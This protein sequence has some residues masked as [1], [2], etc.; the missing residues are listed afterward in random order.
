MNETTFVVT[1]LIA[2]PMEERENPCFCFDS[3]QDVCNFM[4][5][6]FA[7]GYVVEV[8]EVPNDKK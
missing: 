8:A 6:C 1:L 2:G 3:F 5:L 4:K 7:N